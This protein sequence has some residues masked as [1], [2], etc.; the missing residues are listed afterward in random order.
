M[1]SQV[2]R[3]KNRAEENSTGTTITNQPTNFNFKLSLHSNKHY[4]VTIYNFYGH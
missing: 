1:V 3:N 2:K 4:L